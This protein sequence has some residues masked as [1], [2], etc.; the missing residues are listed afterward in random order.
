MTLPLY[1]ASEVQ[2]PTENA[3]PTRNNLINFEN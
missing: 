1:S 3:E 2:E